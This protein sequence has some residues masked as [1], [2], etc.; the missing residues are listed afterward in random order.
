MEKKRREEK[1]R[2]REEW[3]V[4]LE[5]ESGPRQNRASEWLS[6]PKNAWSFFFFSFLK[7]I[8]LATT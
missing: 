6:P 2:G 1:K 4:N 7:S 8:I 3:V 5:C